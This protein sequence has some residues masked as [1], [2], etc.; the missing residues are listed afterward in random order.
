VRELTLAIL[1]DYEKIG[2]TNA[3]RLG[4]IMKGRDDKRT[5]KSSPDYKALCARYPTISLVPINTANVTSDDTSSS[6]SQ[7]LRAM[8]TSSDAR[9]VFNFAMTNVP[10]EKEFL[11][12]LYVLRPSIRVDVHSQLLYSFGLFQGTP[13]LAFLSVPVWIW[14]AMPTNPAYKYIGL[15]RSRSL[16]DE[17]PITKRGAAR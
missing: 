5:F 13:A 4:S 9:I 15:V 16:L 2:K 6:S 10:K 12:M 11:R 14:C 17:K 8:L 1:D 3:W 7:T